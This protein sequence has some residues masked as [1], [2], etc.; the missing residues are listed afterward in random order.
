MEHELQSVQDMQRHIVELEAARDNDRSRVRDWKLFA[1]LIGLILILGIAALGHLIPMSM[2]TLSMIAEST[3]VVYTVG[4]CVILIGIVLQLRQSGLS[5]MDS[6]RM[7]DM[8]LRAIER[9]VTS[10]P[11]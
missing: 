5:R 4:G 8:Q 3:W 10:D 7:R 2:T 6:Q 11:Q 1:L 9:R